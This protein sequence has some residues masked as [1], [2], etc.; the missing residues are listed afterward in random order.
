[1]TV[2]AEAAADAIPAAQTGVAAAQSTGRRY[3]EPRPAEAT[4]AQAGNDVA[5]PGREVFMGS[6]P[7]GDAA[8]LLDAAGADEVSQG[9]ATMACPGSRRGRYQRAATTAPDSTAR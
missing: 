9:T 6:A 1:M 8:A 7:F 2:E 4:A 5:T 3:A